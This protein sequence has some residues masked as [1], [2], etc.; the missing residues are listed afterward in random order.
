MAKITNLESVA[1]RL[2]P[3]V[4]LDDRFQFTVTREELTWLKKLVE[5]QVKTEDCQM[6]YY[7]KRDAAKHPERKTID[8]FRKRLELAKSVRY[9]LTQAIEI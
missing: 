8:R 9:R 7:I 5:V 6:Q 4:S 3:T 1:V 2:N